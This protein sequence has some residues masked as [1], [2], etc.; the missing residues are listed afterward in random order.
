MEVDSRQSILGSPM[1]SDSRLGRHLSRDHLKIDLALFLPW[2]NRESS[3]IFPR[4]FDLATG[5]VSSYSRQNAL[6][7]V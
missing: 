3:K 2:L 4:A 1:P 6:K 5:W 7:P